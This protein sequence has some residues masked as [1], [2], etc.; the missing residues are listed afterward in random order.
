M[1][2]GARRWLWPRGCLVGDVREHTDSLR[3]LMMQYPDESCSNIADKFATAATYFYHE[4]A[5]VT[6]PC[7]S[8][9]GIFSIP[10]AADAPRG[11]ARRWIQERFKHN[12][13]MSMRSCTHNHTGAHMR[14]RPACPDTRTLK[15]PWQLVGAALPRERNPTTRPPHSFAEQ[16]QE[17]RCHA[18]SQQVGDPVVYYTCLGLQVRCLVGPRVSGTPRSCD[19]A[20]IPLACT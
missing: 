6:A 11:S 10:G 2:S 20:L 9:R 15:A 3:E 12:S 7:A 16:Y 14:T 1:K 4:A 17:S 18:R 5:L 13:Y 8:L 19:R